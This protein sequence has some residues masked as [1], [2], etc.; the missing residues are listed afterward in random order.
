MCCVCT[1]FSSLRSQIQ[2]AK[3]AVDLAQHQAKLEAADAALKE[4]AQALQQQHG[5]AEDLPELA[6]MQLAGMLLQ[7]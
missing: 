1:I 5:S 6:K 7:R 4:H 3:A 2:A